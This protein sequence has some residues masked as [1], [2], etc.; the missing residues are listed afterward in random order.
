MC[1]IAGF[2]SFNWAPDYI[3][4]MTRRLQHRGP[5]AE[6]FF[7]DPE[8]GISLGHRRL[9]ILDLSSAANQ[10]FISKNKRYVIVF[11]GEI[12]NYTEIQ[13]KYQLHTITTSDTEIVAELFALKGIAALQEFNGMFAIAV[14]DTLEQ[15]L[16]L[17][18][19]R[20]GVK[21]LYYYHGPDG[22]AFASEL[23]ALLEL[24][25]PR[26]INTESLKDY[27]FLEYVPKPN[28][29]FKNIHKLPNGSY[30]FYDSFRKTDIRPYYDLR[31]KYHPI[32]ISDSEALDQFQDL[33]SSSVA[34]RTISDVPVGSFL[35]GGVDS[36]LVT[37]AFQQ[38]NTRPVETFTIGFDVSDFDERTY[39][40]QVAELLHTNHHAFNLSADAMFQVLQ[41]AVDYYD[42]PF[43][44]S[45]VLPSLMVSKE[46]RAYATVALSGDGGDELFMGYNTYNWYRRITALKRMG[47]K[48][49][50]KLA[51]KLLQMAGGKY[52]IKSRIFSGHADKNLYLNLWSQEQQMFTQQEIG[53]LMSSE[54][55]HQTTIP[56]WES[57]EKANLSDSQR[58]SFFDVEYYLADDLMYKMD[59]ASMRYG[60]EV[61]SPFLDYRMVEFAMN[62]PLN[63]K[64]RQ[65]EQKY[66]LKKALENHLP[67]SLIYRKKW[68]FPAPVEEWLKG[69]HKGLI[70]QCLSKEQ[71]RKQGIF[72]EHE[73]EKLIQSFRSG[74]YYHSKRIWSLIV[75]QLWYEKYINISEPIIS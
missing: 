70:D 8:A 41:E 60:L 37:A 38:L 29:I 4:K 48:P 3:H 19:D 2:I 73:I 22:F 34:Y 59:I 12:Y 46:T 11:N 67:K 17:I 68:G 9:S 36:S 51:E 31:E 28:T 14:W 49:S 42:E 27:L 33:F 21:P 71:I 24:P 64:I 45:S 26:H 10:P 54:Y 47:G 66:L 6:G 50:L 69:A 25:I 44:V 62:L 7:H 15:T 63:L 39:A 43:A 56:Y 16:T 55:K 32:Q 18:R 30:L 75:F 23:K 13:K 53:R 40:K 1:G 57:L 58:I 74:N 65:G 5:D 35:S 52:A 61:R 20:F 72:N